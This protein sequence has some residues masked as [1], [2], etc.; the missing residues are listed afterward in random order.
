MVR[1]LILFQGH[2]KDLLLFNAEINLFVMRN[3]RPGI[4]Q[5]LFLD[6]DINA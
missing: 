4:L 1:E 3:A 6:F 2:C 5:M